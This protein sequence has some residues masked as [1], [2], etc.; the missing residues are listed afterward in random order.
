MWRV[1]R[2]KAWL[3]TLFGNPVILPVT[4]FAYGRFADMLFAWNKWKGHW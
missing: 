2:G 3:A 4:R 1:T